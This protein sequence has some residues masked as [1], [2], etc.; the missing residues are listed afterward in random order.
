MT[1]TLP[2]NAVCLLTTKSAFVFCIIPLCMWLQMCVCVCV[3]VCLVPKS[4]LTLC[5]PMVCSLP[6]SSVQ[7]ICQ[8]RILE[9]VVIP[10]SRDFANP[11]IKPAFSELAGG[12]FTTEPLGRPMISNLFSMEGKSSIEYFHLF[13]IT[14]YQTI[15]ERI[16]SIYNLLDIQCKEWWYRAHSPLFIWLFRG[17]SCNQ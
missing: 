2:I 14:R 8:V 4:C 9:W 16:F 15:R 10:F 6:G 1:N 5:D 7:G 12:F 17:G 13:L 3:C 11:R